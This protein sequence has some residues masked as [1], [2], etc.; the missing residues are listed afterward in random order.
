MGFKMNPIEKLDF[1]KIVYSAWSSHCF[2]FLP[3]FIGS[4]FMAVAAA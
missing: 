1:A 2:A 3:H 4:W